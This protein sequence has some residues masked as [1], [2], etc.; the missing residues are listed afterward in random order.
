MTAKLLS[1]RERQLYVLLC[2]VVIDSNGYRIKRDA[3]QRWI[4]NRRRQYRPA[5]VHI[6]QGQG[7]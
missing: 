5:R 7:L 1:P 2:E 4:V 3:V 6:H